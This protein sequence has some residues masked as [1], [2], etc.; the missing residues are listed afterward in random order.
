VGCSISLRFGTEFDHVTPG[1]L[2]TFKVKWSNVKVTAWKRRLIAKLL[3]TFGKSWS[4][5]LMRTSEFW[6]EADT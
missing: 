1:V 2:Q 4:L 6:L 3:L 5:I